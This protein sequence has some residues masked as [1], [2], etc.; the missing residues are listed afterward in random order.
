MK[1]QLQQVTCKG[2]GGTVFK[3]EVRTEYFSYE[4]GRFEKTLLYRWCVACKASGHNRARVTTLQSVPDEST[5]AHA[6]SIAGC[7]L[8]DWSGKDI[9][10]YLR[11][12]T[13]K[14]KR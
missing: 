6:E 3:H 14:Q 10:N 9:E 8:D 12:R 4:Y 5:L 1:V 11:L 13:V 2:C 7:A